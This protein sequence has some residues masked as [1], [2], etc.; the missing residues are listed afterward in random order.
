MG[1]A[2]RAGGLVSIIVTCRGGLE[3]ARPCVAALMRHTRRPWEL[4]VAADGTADGDAYLRGVADA[5][6]VPVA[7]I[8]DP[9]G[10]GPLA[11]RD[12]GLRAARGDYLVLLDGAA[13][14]TDGWLDQLVALAES[15][16]RI[17]LA[18][19]MSNDAPPPQRVEPVPYADPEA[20][21][22]FAARWREEHR[23]RW[24]TAAGLSDFCLLI[25]R[26]ALEAA[27]APDG[28]LA[29]ED[30]CQRARRA[31]YE[32]AVAHDLFVHRGPFGAAAPP[33]GGRAGAAGSR[34][35]VSL[36][37]IVR[38]EEANLPACLGS[39][40]DLFDEVVVVDTGS[41]DRTAEVA[42]SF[43]ARVVDFAWVDDFAAA[44]NAALDHA[45]GDYVFWLD[46]DDLIEPPQRDRLRALLGGLRRGDEAAYVVRCAC[47][48]DPAGGGAQVVDHVR[49]FPR[50]ADVRWSYRVHEQV[51]PA[52][53]GA[54]VGVRWTDVVVRHTGYVDPAVRA[55]KLGRDARILGAELAERPDDP[56]VLFNLGSVAVEREDWA[57]ALGHLRRSLAG[58]APGD[59]IVRKLHALIARCH[60]Q[61]GEPAAALEAC[62]AGLA[63]DPD[64]AELLFRMAVVHR[65]AGDAARA[66][67]CW[68]RVLGLRRPERFASVDAGIYGHLTRRNLAALAEERGDRAAAARLW[69]EVLAE[70]PGD[71]AALAAH[72]RLAGA[73]P[74]A[75]ATTS[76]GRD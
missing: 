54:G 62:A 36:T 28:P 52:L 29:G 51:L 34:P 30:L 50:R 64:D 21:H 63:A 57:A 48:P 49:L 40:A 43:G 47:D 75:P 2:S 9:E 22:R 16:P 70:C 3:S 65:L 4:I 5:A 37:M 53:R 17:G 67:A 27:R 38:D 32:L 26:R 66:E 55:R 33:R 56:F 59:S 46:A 11:A 10:R 19:P 8:A 6:P 35:T 39:A 72:R 25:K 41:V 24:L 73:S 71:A 14:V 7:V 45:A 61:L 31:G 15:G 1:V 76:V 42:R 69:A 68:R 13:I 74:T 18:G 23:G 60:Q 12:R 44:R 20:M 58:S